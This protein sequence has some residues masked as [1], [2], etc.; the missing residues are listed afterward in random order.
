MK[1]IVSLDPLKSIIDIFKN[2]Y[3]G[4]AK[5]PYQTR[6]PEIE[7]HEHMDLWTKSDDAGNGSG[8]PYHTR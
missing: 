4:V 5:L 7:H 1:K 6:K 2:I 8:M 3:K